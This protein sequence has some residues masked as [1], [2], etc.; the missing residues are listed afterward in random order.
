MRCPIEDAA[1][2]TVG[3]P[4]YLV[5]MGRKLDRI[6]NCEA[7]LLEEARQPPNKIPLPRSHS[8]GPIPSD[9]VASFDLC[10][11]PLSDMP[12]RADAVCCCG[13]TGPSG[14][15]ARLPSW[16]QNGR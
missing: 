2:P 10:F 16:T 3:S 1:V 7:N 5:A 15:A 6:H 14:I 12:R 11:W 9:M 8:G 4:S 13:W